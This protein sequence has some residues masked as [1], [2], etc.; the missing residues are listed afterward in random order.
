MRQDRY[1]MDEET[2]KHEQLISRNMAR[3]LVS[4]AGHSGDISTVVICDAFL[5][6]TC[7]EQDDVDRIIQVAGEPEHYRHLSTDRHYLIYDVEVS[8]ET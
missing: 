8:D 2:N 4:A 1:K 6:I 3:A 5:F 7:I